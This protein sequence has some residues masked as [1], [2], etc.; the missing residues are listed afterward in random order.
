MSNG[1]SGSGGGGVKAMGGGGGGIVV[2]RRAGRGA[3]KPGGIGGGGGGG[4]GGG[5]TSGPTF[6]T[7]VG[8]SF[9][10][11]SSIGIKTSTGG[12]LATAGS[13]PRGSNLS[14]FGAESRLTTSVPLTTYR[15]A[16]STTPI[17]AAS[18]PSSSLAGI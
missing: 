15:L 13:L 9:S 2:G 3:E 12:A 1:D 16:A 8:I 17:D 5:V 14:F 7:R 4:G 6:R 11:S 10:F 18:L